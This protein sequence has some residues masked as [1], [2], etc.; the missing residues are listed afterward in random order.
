M[1]YRRTPAVQ[2]RLDG[3]RLGL[4]EAAG[5]VLV[6]G[7][8]AAC[9]VAAV[10][11]RAGVATGTVY[12][13]FVNKAELVAEI[14]RSVVSGEVEA[15]RSA[16]ALRS[17]AVEQATAVVETFAGRALKHPRR[18]YALLAEPVDPAVDALRLEF[19]RAF[20]DVIADTIAAGVRGGELPPQ[21]PALVAAALVG[22]IGEALVGPLADGAAGPDA[23]PTLVQFVR[24][25]IGGPVHAHA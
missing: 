16:V 11:A 22:A 19:R 12:T 23:V 17:G 18:A 1:A 6:D 14:F 21:D 13:H 10:A 3:Q 7:G 25:S 5:E 9:T 20:R 8:Y 15:V 2:A 4:L 24:R